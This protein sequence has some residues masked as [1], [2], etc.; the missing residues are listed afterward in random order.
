MKKAYEKLFFEVIFFCPEDVVRTS[1][2]G[3]G[4][5]NDDDNFGDIGDFVPNP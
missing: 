1:P 2:E 5:D 4:F 3:G